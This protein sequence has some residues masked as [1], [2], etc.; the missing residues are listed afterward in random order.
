MP[1]SR[2]GSAGSWRARRR[3]ATTGRLLTAHGRPIEYGYGAGGGLAEQQNV[4]ATWPGSAE[5]PSAGRPFTDRVLVRLMARGVLVA[6]LVLHTGVSSPEAHEPPQPERFAVAEATAR[7]V[8]ETREA[9]A[10]GRRRHDRRSAPW[11][12]VRRRGRVHPMRGG[13]TWRSGRIGAR[14]W[15][16]ACSPASTSPQA[17]HLMMLEA[18]AGVDWSTAPTPRTFR[19]HVPLARVRPTEGHLRRLLIVFLQQPEP[20]VEE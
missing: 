3:P 6:P 16:T 10:G 5:M 7:L 19:P 18:V 8:N 14:G 2:T 1:A 12:R 9:A 13:P 20:F 11:R 4:Y 17:S 15:S